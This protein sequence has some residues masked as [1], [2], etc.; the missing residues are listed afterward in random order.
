MTSATAAVGVERPR[1][2]GD[3][4]LEQVRN[5]IV[6][7]QL[8]PGERL[9]EANIAKMLNVSKTPV[10][11]ALIQL[12]TIGLVVM[13]EDNA[14]VVAPSATLVR[15]AYEV[16]AVLEGLSARLAAERSDP[17]QLAGVMLLAEASLGAARAR[18]QGAFHTYDREF[19][20]AIAIQAN[21]LTA[22]QRIDDAVVLCDTLRQRDALTRWDS[23]LCGKAHV[24]IAR[25]IQSGDG[26]AAALGMQ[27]HIEYV[28]SK[29]LKS[30]A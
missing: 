16:R 19:H 17:A 21:N 6:T 2:V 25:S 14:H 23:D 20:Q 7:K 13:V 10:R 8:S 27:G 11:E 15:E 12:R 9:R 28:M 22:Q 30:L 1:K 26:D 29:V 18:D 5:L 3:I 4:V 24:D